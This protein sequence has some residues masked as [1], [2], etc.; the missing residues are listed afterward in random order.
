MG[1]QTGGNEICVATEMTI[2][3]YRDARCRQC[4]GKRLSGTTWLSFN[5]EG[6]SHLCDTAVSGP[7]L[8]CLASRLMV[9]FLI[10]KNS[11]RFESPPVCGNFKSH[12][13]NR[14]PKT[15]RIAIEALLVFTS[16]IGPDSFQIAQFDTVAIYRIA[17]SAI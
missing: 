12:D 1:V 17:R 6:M 2:Q 13:S 7:T 4:T 16:K 11:Q 15:S 9:K 14:K 3:C 8:R 5:K 10:N